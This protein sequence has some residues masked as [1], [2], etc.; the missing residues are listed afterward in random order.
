MASFFVLAG[1]V[2]TALAIKI[3]VQSLC[4]SARIRRMRQHRRHL[5]NELLGESR[6]MEGYRFITFGP[7]DLD[8][9]TF[10]NTTLHYMRHYESAEAFAEAMQQ[11]RTIPHPSQETRDYY[12]RDLIPYCERFETDEE[13]WQRA[14][15]F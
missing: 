15:L 13:A 6:Q 8:V 7:M 3:F 11:V 1:I 4:R 9:D 10:F 12:E 2:L 5:Q 14:M